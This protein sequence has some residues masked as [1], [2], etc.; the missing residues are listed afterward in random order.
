M[1]FDHH[2]TLEWRALFSKDPLKLALHGTCKGPFGCPWG[3]RRQ[4]YRK[5]TVLS[6]AWKN[7]CSD[8]TLSEQVFKQFHILTALYNWGS[9]NS[10]RTGGT[11]KRYKIVMIIWMRW[12]HIYAE[13][14]F[15]LN[16]IWSNWSNYDKICVPSLTVIVSF[17]IWCQIWL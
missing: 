4:I 16:T 15:K 5:Y 11:I 12:S 13:H 9:L 3:S 17:A 7:R 1:N 10:F 6:I 8:M 14:L 2:E